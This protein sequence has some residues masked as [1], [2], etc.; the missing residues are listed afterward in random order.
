MQ[1]MIMVKSSYDKRRYELLGYEGWIS[2]TEGVNRWLD[3]QW[4]FIIHCPW[5]WKRARVSLLAGVSPELYENPWMQPRK[6]NMSC[7]I[8]RD[9]MGN[10]SRVTSQAVPQCSA[11]R[12]GGDS[13]R[14]LISYLLMRTTSLFKRILRYL[15]PLKH[16]YRRAKMSYERQELLLSPFL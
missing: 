2:R 10:L 9:T 15:T 16:P 8:V 4:Y 5:S 7:R 14:S 11:S 13:Q 1:R 6:A 3:E 12:L